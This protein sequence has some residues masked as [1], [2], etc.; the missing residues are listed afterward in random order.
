[1]FVGHALL[2]FAV[3]AFLGERLGYDRRVVLSTAVLAGLFGALPDVDVVYGLAGLAAGVDPEAF[4]A[5]GNRTH[6]GLTHALPIAVV[7]ALAAGSL[8]AARRSSSR[9]RPAALALAGAGFVAVVAVALV[10]SGPLGGA[11]AVLFVGGAAVLALAARR[12][13]LAPS[14]VTAAALVGL[15][16]H[17]FGDLFTG[18]PPAMLYPFDAVLAAERV[19]L[20]ADPTLHLLGAFG[21]ELAA[22]WLAVLAYARLTDRPLGTLVDRRA[23]LGAVYGPAALV[24]PAPTLAVSYQFVYSVL[25]VGVTGA[26]TTRSPRSLR[27]LDLSIAARALATVTVAAVA[28]LCVYLLASRQYPSPVG[29]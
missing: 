19:T 7:T 28:Y 24:L 4:W 26:V 29:L 3:V 22:A 9:T 16:T 12:R 23:T 11:V 18:T 5:A 8:A 2:A 21:L 6:R 25:G 15:L 27:R 10:V 20:A 1:V 17:S 13:A 14:A